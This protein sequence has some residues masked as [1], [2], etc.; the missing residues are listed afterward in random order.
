[1]TVSREN[2][3]GRY[4]MQKDFLDPSLSWP[5]LVYLVLAG[6]LGWI[7]NR[8][9]KWVLLWLNRKKPAAEVDES[10]ARTVKTFAE[11]RRINAEADTELNAII[12]RLHLR[13][14][15]MQ[16]G[17]DE[18]RVERDQWKEKAEAAESQRDI[19]GY[20]IERLTAANKLGITMKQLDEMTPPKPKS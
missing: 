9:Y 4:E 1:M 7:G 6:F 17:I 15:Q 10:Q 14:D 16:V 12:Q 20:F 11:A 18:I 8:A 5:S 13:I 3:Q 19:D 2:V